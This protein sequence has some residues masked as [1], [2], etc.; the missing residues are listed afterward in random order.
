VTRLREYSCIGTQCRCVSFGYR[1]LFRCSQETERLLFMRSREAFCF[2]YYLCAPS[3]VSL[4]TLAHIVCKCVR[5]CVHVR[6]RVYIYI[7]K[8]TYIFFCGRARVR[9]CVGA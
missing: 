5:A 8:H 6:A 4:H 3:P 9:V 2:A 7:Y 1:T